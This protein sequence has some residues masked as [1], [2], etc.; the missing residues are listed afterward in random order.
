L[1]EYA[2]LFR[3]PGDPEEPTADEARSAL[4]IAREVHEAILS[5]VPPESRP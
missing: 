2:W 5:R 4:A 3:Y 1:T